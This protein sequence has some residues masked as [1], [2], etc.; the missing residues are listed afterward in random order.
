MILNNQ[1]NFLFLKQRRTASTSLE[2]LL[3]KFCSTD[4]IITKINRVNAGRRA[5][6]LGPSSQNYLD[7]DEPYF[8]GLHL[9]HNLNHCVYHNV[10]QLIKL[11][12]F[13]R[14]LFGYKD[15]SQLNRWMFKK[16]NQKYFG[17]MPVALVRQRI[18]DEKFYDAFKFTVVRNPF[19][20]ILSWYY[21]ISATGGKD[22]QMDFQ[23][24]V[25]KKSL[26]F[27]ESNKEV[28]V[29]DNKSMV[30]EILHYESLNEELPRI[31][32][33]LGLPQKNLGEIYSKVKTNSFTRATRGY[34]LIDK[35][36]QEIIINSAEY[37]FKNCG[38]SR[39]LPD[40]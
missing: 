29:E 38:Y 23:K 18:G 2:I 12:P 11:L 37:F 33:R 40:R 6:S 21:W 1:Y 8:H 32:E 15:P 5:G 24:F 31:S 4:D 28:F 26:E 25:Q 34:E 39:D 13:S 19:D 20:Q 35:Q 36:S 14:M 30:D 10:K 17:H 22:L 27:F 7:P 16:E 9:K 3:S